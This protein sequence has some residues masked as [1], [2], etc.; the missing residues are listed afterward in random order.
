M[1]TTKVNESIRIAK[2]GVGECWDD[3]SGMTGQMPEGQGEG[4]MT[5]TINMPGKNISVT[6]D[7]AD[8]IANILKLA[9]IQV[10]GMSADAEMPAEMPTAMPGAEEP[11]VMYVGAEPTV[12]AGD[13]PGDND[14][15]GDHDMT[16]H[17]IEDDEEVATEGNEFSGALA[18]AKAEGK[19]EFEVD[20]KK[21]KVDGSGVEEAAGDKSYTSKGGAVTQTATGLKHQAGSGVYGGTETDSEEEARKK[22]DNEAAKKEVGEAVEELDEETARILQLAGVTNEAQSAAQKAAFAK[23]IAAKGGDK[24]E[25]K[26]EEKDSNKKPDADSDGV[27]DWADKK[28][29]KEVKEQA[30]ATN[31]IFGQGVYEQSYARILELAGLGESK[32]MNSP[33]GTSMDEPK[34]FDN[35]P[36]ARGQGAGRKDFGANRA[37]GQ[38]ENPMGDGTHT[39]TVEEQFETAMGEYRKFVAESIS[40]KK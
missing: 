21:Y 22:A 36:S 7:S 37:N 20:G 33:E 18:A 38:G 40:R 5:V 15:D 17:K 25:D 11:A 1:K 8:E 35:L 28:D 19:D 30:P 24:S 29:D 27:P 39:V 23:M 31:S 34:L 3:M 26:V 13:V 2:E 6:T 10:G 9:G 32:L 4:P 16:D 14:G 12:A